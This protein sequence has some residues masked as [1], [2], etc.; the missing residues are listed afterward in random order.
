MNVFSYIKK[1]NKKY[2]KELIGTDRYWQKSP[3][4]LLLKEATLESLAEYGKNKKVLDAGAGRLAYRHLIKLFTNNYTSSDFKRT[5]DELDVVTDIEKMSFKDQTFD[6]VFC[7]QVLEHVPHPNKALAEINRILKNKGK[8]VIT[9]PL[10]GYIHNAPYDF[11]RYTK[12][13]LETLATDNGFKVIKLEELGGF[14]SFLGYVRST[15]LMPLFGVPLVGSFI[16]NFNYILSKIDIFL[17]KLIPNKKVFPL[18]YLLILE[19][20]K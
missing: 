19:K 8:V 2:S 17:D 6:L 11:Y 9:V 4:N 14:F 12:F 10:L 1:T 18:N 15:F 3:S 5:H 13:G 16:F 7:S 20:K